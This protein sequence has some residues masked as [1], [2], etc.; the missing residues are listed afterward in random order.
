VRDDF[1][2]AHPEESQEANGE[3]PT[4]S[5]SAPSK[6]ATNGSAVNSPS[7]PSADET[8][9]DDT[10]NPASKGAKPA[11]TNRIPRDPPP[12]AQQIPRMPQ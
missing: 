5:P 9:T 3:V 2:S 7:E 1:G 6:E 12:A 4:R 10:A 8:A 11:T